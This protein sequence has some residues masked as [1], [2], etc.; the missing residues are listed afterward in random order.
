MSKE[1]LLKVT[2][3]NYNPEIRRDD[4]FFNYLF[5]SGFSHF[6]LKNKF[7]KLQEMI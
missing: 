3:S 5:I 2:L 7:Q 4:F 1:I 6:T